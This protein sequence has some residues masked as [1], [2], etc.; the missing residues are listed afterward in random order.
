VRVVSRSD[1]SVLEG[2]VPGSELRAWQDINDELDSEPMREAFDELLERYSEQVDRHEIQHQIDFRRGLV[3]V[4]APLRE[5]LRMP[6]TMDVEPWSPA[7][8]SREELSAELA[9]IG[10][11]EKG[12]TTA[13]VLSQEPLFDR[14]MWGTPHAFGAAVILT[15]LATELGIDAGGPLFAH[16]QFDRRR[17]K[18]LL[19]S[20]A[21]Q[22]KDAIAAAARSAYQR[23]FGVLPPRLE[24]DPWKVAPA[25]RK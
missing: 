15:S 14:S 19:F 10:T 8:R 12:A 23:L 6:D 24:F 18:E 11:T 17:A 16:G 13:L 3:V 9:S 1:M 20:I 22:P 4:P 5:I 2:R 21:E 25:W 7:A